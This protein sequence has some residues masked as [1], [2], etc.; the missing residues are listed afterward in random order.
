MDSADLAF[1]T[2]TD[3][4]NELLRRKTFLGVIVHAED[5]LRQ[6]GWQGEK[7]FRVHFNSNLDRETASGLLDVIAERMLPLGED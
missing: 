6:Q 1:Y 7:I 2:T 5:E 4:I 3:L